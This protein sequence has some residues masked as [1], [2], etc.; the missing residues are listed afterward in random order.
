VQKEEPVHISHLMDLTDFIPHLMVHNL[1][2]MVH[3]LHLINH[4]L[5]VMDLKSHL[6]DI[7]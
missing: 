4:N 1:H 7:S 5:H 6:T 3:N 2:L